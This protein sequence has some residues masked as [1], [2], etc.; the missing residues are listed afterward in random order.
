MTIAAMPQVQQDLYNA[1]TSAITA[2]GESLEV[3]DHAPNPPLDEYIRIDGFNVADRSFKDRERGRHSF[4][5]HYFSRPVT[6]SAQSRGQIRA[7]QVIGFL[8]AAVM[9]T[10]LNGK[11]PDFE[12]T[13]IDSDNDGTTQHGFARYS[14][15]LL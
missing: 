11:K 2:E 9:S 6:G 4:M 1:L 14:I 8:H 10:T 15:T 3:L 13:E 5:V 7:K 12:Y